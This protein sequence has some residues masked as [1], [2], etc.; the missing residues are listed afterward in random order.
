MKEHVLSEEEER[1][2]YLVLILAMVWRSED[3]DRARKDIK[4]REKLYHEFKI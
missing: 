1:F 2:G 4:Y 3:I